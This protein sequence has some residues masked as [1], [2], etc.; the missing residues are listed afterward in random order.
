MANS[1]RADSD[2]RQNPSGRGAKPATEAMQRGL[3]KAVLELRARM[4]WS[5]DDLA[6]EMCKMA[7]RMGVGIKPNRISIS[8]WENGETAPSEEHRVVLARIAGRNKDTARLAELFRAPV[9][10]WRIVGLVR[11]NK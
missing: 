6:H 10:A 9:S 1:V 4:N 3:S 5:Q 11:D 2:S 8:R 7:A